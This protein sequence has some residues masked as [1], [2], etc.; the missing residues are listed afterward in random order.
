LLLGHADKAADL[1]RRAC[2]A[3]PK[4]YFLHL[5]LCAALG[6]QGDLG[7]AKAALA[8]ALRLKPEINTLARYRAATPW[9]T[10]PKHWALRDKTLNVG[11]RRAG[12][13]DE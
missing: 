6:L 4:L 13:P 10:N 11:L 8:E 5:N 9:I 2:T 3:S 1:F 7:G 12:F